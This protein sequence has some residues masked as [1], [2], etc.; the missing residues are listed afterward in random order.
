[1]FLISVIH[2]T[3]STCNG[4][5]AKTAAG[6]VQVTMGD[7]WIKSNVASVKAGTVTF[8]AANQ[9]ATTHGFGIVRA[10]A[11]VSGGVLDQSTML[12][13]GKEIAGGASDTVTGKLTPGSYELICHVPGHYTAGQH[14]PFKVTG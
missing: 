3:D 4:W 9:G 10:P 12:L 7:M 2:A 5:S 13:M 8:K 11:K 1:V 6:T 14:I